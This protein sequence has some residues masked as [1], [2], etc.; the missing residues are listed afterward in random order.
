MKIVKMSRLF[1]AALAVG[2]C[3]V[4]PMAQASVAAQVQRAKVG[5]VDVVVYPMDVKDVVTV[6]GTMPL[7]DAVVAS[8]R[9]NPAVPTL[10]ALMVQRGTTVHDKYQIADT[11]SALGA[12][13]FINSD[14]SA[15][16]VYGKSLK[17]DMPTVVALLAEQL[18]TPSLDPVEFDK[19]KAQLTAMLRQGGDDTDTRAYEALTGKLFAAGSPNASIPREAMLKAV[20]TATL[21]QVK[22]FHAR[23][24]GPDHM[25]L[26]FTGDVDLAAVRGA[27]A[28]AVKGWSGGVDFARSAPKSPAAQAQSIEV[29][30]KDKASVSVM[31][32]QAT[33]LRHADADYL[34]LQVGVNVLGS[35]FTGRLMSTVRDK[36]GLTYGIGA[37]LFGDDIVDGGFMMQ[38]TFAPELLDKGVASARRQLD[39]WWQHGVTADELDAR[40]QALVGRF[41]LQLG[42]TE[43][44]AQTLLMALIRGQDLA[45]LDAYPQKLEAVTLEQVNAAIRH[46]LDPTKMVRVEAGSFN[47]P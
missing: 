32:G 17:K 26:V 24:Y 45:S 1:A 20:D 3:A 41:Q 23:Y 29:A 39:K 19:A 4:V 30:M 9:D 27:V 36:E 21:A 25:T 2:L 10:A 40:K 5:P 7:G 34:P 42:T 38:A 22:A 8:R 15:L 35:G 31:W 13:S 37:D 12:Q 33:G 46:H 16:T 11:L 44:M 28:D 47:K 43:G 18:R 14:D 6:M